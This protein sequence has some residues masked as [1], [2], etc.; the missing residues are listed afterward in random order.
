[1]ADFWANTNFNTDIFGGWWGH[2]CASPSQ[3]GWTPRQSEPLDIFPDRNSLAGASNEAHSA[4]QIISWA[5]WSS[6]QGMNDATDFGT[7]SINLNVIKAMTTAGVGV[8]LDGS[9]KSIHDSYLDLLKQTAPLYSQSRLIHK[10]L[11][12]YARAGIFLAPKDAII[13]IDHSY[14]NRGSGTGP[15][16]TIWTGRDYTFSGTTVSTSSPPFNTQF[17]IEVAND[18]A[19]TSNLVSS[20]WLGGVV[21][22]AGGTAT[23]V[24][25]TPNWNTLKPGDAIFYRVTTKDAAGGNI[26]Q[27]WN[28]G[29]SFLTG[30][31]VGK[32]AIN[33]TGT[34]DCSCSASAASRTSSGMAL[35]PLFP[36]G[37][38]LF[39]RMRVKKDHSKE[40]EK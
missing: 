38:M 13:D 34:K 18:E 39:F 5:N 2:N 35:I 28:P 20:G 22:A 3:A 30:V 11:A 26:R 16:F 23:W 10:L 12:G 36:I 31:K 7:L 17:L 32:A 33:G 19:F 25:P 40:G 29:N 24:L 4:G 8:L 21:S 14:L 1:M 37:L 27:S 9:S 6:R 15:T